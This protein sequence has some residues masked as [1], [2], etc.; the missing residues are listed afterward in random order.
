MNGRFEIGEYAISGSPYYSLLYAKN[1][2]KD[3]FKLGE[4]IIKDSIDEFEYR[5]FLF[6]LLSPE[7][8]FHYS[9][10]DGICDVY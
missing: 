1:V 8:Q 9:P 4:F 10:I 6:T 3:R 7:E 5:K 2:L